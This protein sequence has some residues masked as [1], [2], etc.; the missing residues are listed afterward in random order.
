MIGLNAIMH[1]I[2][3][4]NAKASLWCKGRMNWRAK[5]LQKIDPKPQKHI[6]IW[7]HA[8]SLG[9]FELLLPLVLAIKEK[10]GNRIYLIGSFFSPS[11]FEQ[12]K[13]HPILDAVTYLPLDSNKNAE[14]FLNI[15]QPDIYI[16]AK[17]EFW[18][19]F[20]E[21]IANRN[22]PAYVV[23]ARFEPNSIYLT[24]LWPLY[25]KA[26]QHFNGWFTQNLNSADALRG[27]DLNRVYFYGDTRVDRNLHISREKVKFESVEAFKS[28]QPI[29]ILGSIWESDLENIRSVLQKI[30]N[31]WK[32]IIAPHEIKPKFL[33][34]IESLFPEQTVRFSKVETSDDLSE[35]RCLLIDNIG[36]LSRLYQYGD[37]AYIG[38]A[39]GKGL[40]NIF[41]PL[42]AGI[43]VI[44]GPKFKKFPEATEAI[45]SEVGYSIKNS[46][47]FEKAFHY[48]ASRP[49]DIL[50]KSINSFL[51]PSIGAADKIASIILQSVPKS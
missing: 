7:I 44:F 4:F 42:A 21:A 18:L 35:N 15:V 34:K 29:L 33:L 20:I 45:V 11:G 10:L 19:F 13:N 12:R 6:R 9:E 25:Q 5:L 41:E 8:A 38:G 3:P 1:L 32:F 30:P 50:Q 37:L 49:V 36:N 28:N 48:F 51:S 22:I 27:K 47:E 26:F 46:V 43:P 17:Y 2:S 14:D 39:F 31:H 40:H 24:K 23:G 16:T